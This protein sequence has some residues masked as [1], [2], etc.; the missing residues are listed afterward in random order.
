M[1]FRER[2][3]IAIQ[4]SY[5]VLQKHLHVHEAREREVARRKNNSHW[6]RALQFK[7][8]GYLLP[9]SPYLSYHQRWDSALWGC[10]T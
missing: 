10:G 5:L 3:C 9:A 1:F 4:S 7:L 2:F 6:Q 8:R